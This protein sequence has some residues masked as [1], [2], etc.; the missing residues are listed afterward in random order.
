[1]LRVRSGSGVSTAR[2][3]PAESVDMA[4]PVVAECV[5]ARA[6]A[7]TGAPGRLVGG[8]DVTA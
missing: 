3:R 4:L 8:K 2:F 5:V 6:V 7:G 1:V